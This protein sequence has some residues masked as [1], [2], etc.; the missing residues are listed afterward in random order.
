MEEEDQMNLEE[1]GKIPKDGDQER[2][3]MCEKRHKRDFGGKWSIQMGNRQFDKALKKK[4][5]WKR[6]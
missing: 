6:G 4:V 3:E 5:S 2:G 1:V